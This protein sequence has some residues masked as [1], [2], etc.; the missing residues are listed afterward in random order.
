MKDLKHKVI[1]GGFAK[2]VAQGANFAIRMGSLMVMA[3]LLAPRDFGLVGMVMA[4]TGVLNLF[5]DFGLSTATVQR[6]HVTDDQ[7]STLFWINVLVGSI[8]AAILMIASPFVAVFYHE[9][10]LV[11]V[12]LVLATSFVF[13]GAGVQHTALLERQMRFTALAT[14][15]TIALLSSITIGIIMAVTGFG[16]WALVAAA[17]SMPLIT[18]SCL[19][20]VTRWIPGR[21]RSKVGLHSI[22]RYGGT[23]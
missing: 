22:L 15:D 19:W 10:R 3:C 21:P 1:R 6:G 7:V 12:S 23:F 8:L 4:F 14:I 2:A 11:W 20:L 13:N 17:V 18:T 16:Y 9:P 5:R